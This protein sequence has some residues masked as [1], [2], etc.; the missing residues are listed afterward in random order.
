MWLQS[1]GRSGTG[2]DV[3]AHGV[4]A[5][6]VLRTD[7]GQ[8]VL[9]ATRSGGGVMTF[10][11][12]TDGTLTLVDSRIFSDVVDPA[13]TGKLALA[14]TATGR[15]LFLGAAEDHLVGYRIAEDGSIGARVSM[16]KATVTAEIMAGN[17]TMLRASALHSD[18]APLADGAW[19]TGTVGLDVIDSGAQAQV[20]AIGAFDDHLAVM[21]RVGTDDIA[22]F[23]A[24]QGLGIAN[25]TALEVIGTDTGHW[26]IVAAAGSASLSVI[27]LTPDGRLQ[28]TDHVTDTRETRFGGVQAL[29]SATC[30]DE[31]LIVAG[32]GDHGLTLFRLSP[33]G[34]LVWLDTLVHHEGAGLYN[35]ASLSAV[36]ID[37]T[38]VVT[39]GSQGD[40]GVGVVTAPL[41]DLGV[42]GQI[43]TGGAGH[44]LLVSS[45]ANAILTGGAG[46]DVFALR[47][48]DGPV[49]ITDFE[50]GLD[51]LDLSDWPMLRG[52]AQLDI[53][54]TS[55]GALISYRDYS[56]HV[57][58]D[59]GAG[60]T[61]AEIF[62]HGLQGPDRLLILN[63]AGFGDGMGSDDT[64]TAP[65]LPQG[66]GPRIVD[67][68][69]LGLAEATVTLI[70]TGSSPYV[71]QT[72]THGHFTLPPS[73]EGTLL[74][75]RFHTAGDPAITAS[76]ALNV[77]RLA[78]GLDAG[79]GPLDYI[80]ADIDRNG[81]VT[82]A[83]A[84]DV[85]R[86]AVGLP[87]SATPEWI[88][89]DASAD[90]GTIT[91]RD[92][93]YEAGMYLDGV[94]DAGDLSFIAM[95]LGNM[96]DMG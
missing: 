18:T 40:P 7:A 22:L 52:V 75:T 50:P 62:P 5:S 80:A 81:Q 8:F 23:G 89:I 26:A 57:G 39:V 51:R 47:M 35:I 54:T 96:T 28:P 4:T 16:D 64:P 58:S 66:D 88:F 94:Q 65:D 9:A 91:A 25:P 83:D 19:Q 3:F 31:V 63:N 21:P 53:S 10:R 82:A 29:A 44:D 87:P 27:A 55:Q 37:Q 46:A 60:L 34:R 12:G 17:D 72:D 49:W 1:R 69:G 42:A 38:L 93:R 13:L 45:P 30:G 14:D 77:L 78:V 95:L 43:A 20:L 92:V 24:D 86:V 32:G 33:D 85:L 61:A 11:V 41:A 2:S 74:L 67:R 6:E 73:P 84:L 15:V 70:P 76:D 90:L 48:Q 36:V 56:V 71:T 68:A 59:S 79:A